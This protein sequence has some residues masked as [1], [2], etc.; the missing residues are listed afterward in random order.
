MQPFQVAIPQ[1]VP[2]NLRARLAHTRW[3]A[4]PAPVDWQY[5]L[6]ARGADV[7]AARF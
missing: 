7:L 5:G 2:D 3:H 6:P 1:P 4:E